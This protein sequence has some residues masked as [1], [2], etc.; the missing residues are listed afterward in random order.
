MT[1]IV[2]SASKKCINACFCAYLSH[3][4]HSFYFRNYPVCEH[5]DNIFVLCCR[6]LVLHLKRYHFSNMFTSSRKISRDVLIP[7]FLTLAEHSTE[8]TYPAYN[9]D[10]ARRNRCVRAASRAP[11]DRSVEKLL[12]IP[13]GTV[14]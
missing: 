1:S 3:F 12:Q 11:R 9:I 8:H 2:K 13:C 4:Y 5:H 14:K 7:R 10:I 6:V